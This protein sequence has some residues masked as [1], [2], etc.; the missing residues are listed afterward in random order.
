MST[1]HGIVHSPSA[2]CWLRPW[3]MA[4]T[5]R[6]SLAHSAPANSLENRAGRLMSDTSDHTVAGE[7]AMSTSAMAPGPSSKRKLVARAALGRQAEAVEVGDRPGGVA[8]A[9]A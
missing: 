7:A 4:P 3:N 6:S 8:R 9:R 2:A 5:P 1:K